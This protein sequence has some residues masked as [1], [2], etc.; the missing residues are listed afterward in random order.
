MGKKL[1][2]AIKA[3]RTGAGY[4]QE[5]L[6][7]K[8]KGVAATDIS[9]YERGVAEPTAAV[10]KEIA[11]ATGVTQKSLVDLMP[12][13]ASSSAKKTTTTT[14]KTTATK[15]SSTTGKSSLQVTAT[16]KKL[17]EMFRKVDK[18][19]QEKVL[20]TLKEKSETP[21]VG[22]IVSTIASTFFG[23]DKS[24]K[25]DDGFDVGDILQAAGEMIFKK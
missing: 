20:A 4:T 7:R 13:T 16:E 3:A 14:K 22:D 5:Q 10:V 12:K 17:V 1:G 8:I 15:T 24:T 6:A 19:T 25:K 9:A 21:D 23:A 2:S 11:K 18:E